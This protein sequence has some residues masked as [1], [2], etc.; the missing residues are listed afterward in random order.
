MIK[1]ERIG[2]KKLKK[3][4]IIAYAIVLSF[5]VGFIIIFMGMSYYKYK[6]SE[7][8]ITDKKNITKYQYHY[9]FISEESDA[10]FWDTV[11]QGAVE[12]GKEQN[13]YVEKMGNNLSVKYSLYD[14][15]QIAIASDVDGIIIEPN[16]E[17]NITELINQAENEGIT[18][19]T[20]LNDS[21]TS[22]RKSFIGINSY[23]QGQSYGKQVAEVA[24]EGKRNV[25]I[26]FDKDKTD[27]SQNIIYSGI[28]QNVVYDD[29][30]LK[31]AYIN[32]ENTFSTEEDIRNII[33]DTDNPAEVLV[34]LSAVDTRCAYQA[35]VDYNKVGE[36]DIIGYY[37][38][39]L[40]LSAIEMNNV[41]STMTI[42]AK[43][44]GAYCVEALTE[45][46]ETERVSDYYPVDIFVIHSGNVAEYIKN[47]QEEATK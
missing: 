47:R 32:T 10:P 5:A 18:V 27:A 15:M 2:F 29:V 28:Q 4:K 46:R 35:I 17:A 7:L 3:D 40:I 13:A 19:V 16:G 42:D 9:A 26:L 33:L 21:P 45:Y 24:R 20:V 37:D 41:H 6:A 34:C 23:N 36:I 31:T 25:T 22:S 30:N 11:Y 43:Q 12:K 1:R 39:D 38:S 44:M 8:G 14:L